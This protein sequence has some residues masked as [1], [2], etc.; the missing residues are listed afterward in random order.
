MRVIVFAI[1]IAIGFA[2]PPLLIL[3]LAWIM[4]TQWE[5]IGLRPRAINVY[6][7][8]CLIL[9]GDRIIEVVEQRE[10]VILPL[11]TPPRRLGKTSPGH[12]EERSRH[13]GSC[14]RGPPHRP[15]LGLLA[16]HC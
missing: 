11:R 13:R 16:R 1:G 9:D 7:D 8:K 2:V 5:A 3:L 4:M 14:H 6:I 12:P 15:G 10:E